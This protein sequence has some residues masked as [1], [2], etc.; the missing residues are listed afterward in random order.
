MTTDTEDSGDGLY[1]RLPWS[2]Q[3]GLGLIGFVYGVAILTDTIKPQIP[4]NVWAVV[5]FAA[6]AYLL[7][8]A[9]RLSR[10]S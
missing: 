8:R 9:V 10:Q 3:L 6:G 1:A 4:S 5:Y 2:V 7:V